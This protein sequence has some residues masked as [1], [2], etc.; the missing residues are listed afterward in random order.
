LQD[1]QHIERLGVAQ[2]GVVFDKLGAV[3]GGDESAIQETAIRRS[4]FRV[5]RG[6][7]GLVDG[8]CSAYIIVVKKR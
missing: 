6:G 8:V 2:P 1:F 3:R 7:G 5:Q 4:A